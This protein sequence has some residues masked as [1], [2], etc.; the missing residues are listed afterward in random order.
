MRKQKLLYGL[1]LA[2][3][4]VVPLLVRAQVTVGSPAQSQSFSV[5]E[6]S[7]ANRAGGLRLPQ[8]T[9]VQRDSLTTAAFKASAK[10]VGLMILNTTTNCIDYWNGTRWASWCSGDPLVTALSCASATASPNTAIPGTAYIGTFTVPYTGS[11]GA[12][13]TAEAVASTGVTGLTALLQSGTLSSSGNLIYT[14]TG[15]PSTYGTAAFPLSFGGQ[16]C[17]VSLPVVSVSSLTCSSA[18]YSAGN[19]ISGSTYS[20]TLTIPYTGGEGA[21]YPANAAIS[22]TGVT[23]L[24]ATLNSGTISSSGNLTYTIAGTPSYTG[25]ADNALFAVSFGGQSCTGTLPVIGVTALTGNSATFST[26]TAI[27]GTAYTATMTIPYTGGSGAAY[28][29][30]TAIS[31]TG[32]TGLTATL[33]AGTLT[34]STGSLT[35]NITGTPSYTGTSNA[36][37]N[38]SFGGQT[39]TAT[40][41]VIGVTALTCSSASYSAGN[42]TSGTTYSGT[43]TIPYTGGSGAAYSTAAVTSTG[44]TGLTATLVA[45]TLA[46]GSGNLTFNITGTPSYSGTANATFAISFGGQSCSATLP[47]IGVTALTCSSASYSA[48]N[49]TS[50]TTYSGT[51]TIPY[52]AGSG[53]AYSTA[54]VTSTGVTGLTATLVASTL[55]SGTGN[56]TYNISGTPAYTGTANATFA[57]SFGGQSC[58]ATLPAIGVTA[59]TG[60]SRTFS[61]GNATSGTTYSGTMTIPYT[62]GSGAAYAAGTAISSTGVT[63]LTATLVAGTLTSS[64]GSLTFNITGTPSYTGTAGAA[65]AISFGG[66]TTTATLPVIGVTALTYTPTFSAGNPAIGVVYTGTMTIPYTGGSGAAYT[67]GTAISS[68]GV[69]G[70][71]ATLVAGTLTSSTGNLTYTIS[72]T[73]TSYGTA[74]FAISFGGQSGSVSFTVSNLAI[75]ALTCSSST[76]SAYAVSGD[77]YSGTMTIPYTGGNGVAYSGGTTISSTGVTGLTATLVAGTLAS[78]SG[79]LS[80]T[81]TGTPTSSGTAVFAISFGGQSCS[82]SLTVLSACPGYLAIGGVYTGTYLYPGSGYLTALASGSNFATT[83]TYFTA[84]GGNLCF[85]KTDGNSGSTDTWAGSNSNCNN[86]SYADGSSTEGWRLPTPAELGNIQGVY[87][88]LS[89]KTTSAS[90]TTNLSATYYWS[91][92][93]YSSSSSWYW[94][95]SISQASYGTTAGTRSVRCVK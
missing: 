20:G 66:Q 38:I 60:S 40:L 84:T 46:S 69:T 1:F 18:T 4:L 48:G 86:G 33:V 78:G 47:V 74:A 83:A 53:A 87:S 94:N 44:V 93:E 56:L 34:S 3:M 52:T 16:S 5:L 62:G 72:G 19:A 61:A 41:P 7:T 75:T 65:F 90:G 28:T 12:G 26:T 59:L 85:Y 10:S 45:G 14:V 31:S 57:I 49:A 23:G 88:T 37:F 8:L 71:T 43:M 35:F 24:T 13:Y 76:F 42:A 15:T 30:G 36:T 64:T 77:T 9:T 80:Y 6:V 32:V 55:A 54:T 95:F 70:L 67:A 21:A 2:V 89:T 11:N 73:P 25:S 39:T 51:M 68:T 92:T 27:S 29:A 82:A 79:S 81:I 91:S 50:G 58:S 63:G 17:S 22:S